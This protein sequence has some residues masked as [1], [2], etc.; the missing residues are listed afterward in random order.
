MNKPS[1][2]VRLPEILAQRNEISLCNSHEKRVSSFIS[3]TKIKASMTLE[4]SL[5][6]PF[7]LFASLSLIS[8]IDVMKIKGCMDVAVAKVGNEIAV[9]SYGGY[10]ADI[11]EP[12]YIKIK[13]KEFLEENLN[14]K[15]YERLLKTVNVTDLSFFQEENIFSFQV[16]YSVTC[17][18]GI[19]ELVPLKLHT[20]Y[21]GHNWRGY[22]KQNEKEKM[23]FVSD[24]ASV[25]HTDKNCT[26]L[27]ITIYKVLY[28]DINAYRNNSGG[29]YGTCNFCNSVKKGG[30]V[31]ITREGEN[32]HTVESCI[33]LTRSIHTV[34]LS[35]VSH[36]EL[37]MR[38]GK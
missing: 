12:F 18:I 19:P 5:V 37:C 29:K 28:R 2:R 13:L 14:E 6:L 7:F 10:V 35:T 8:I 31:Y 3:D 20:T 24:E 32:Y 16:D 36:K 11:I 17:G 33:G 21:Y 1:L 27:N 30:M 9:E 15:D 23:V 4:A 26:Y 38:C 25:Y 34:P 22:R